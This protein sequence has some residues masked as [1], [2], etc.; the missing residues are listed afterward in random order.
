MTCSFVPPHLLRR[1]AESGT[2]AASP[3]TQTLRVDEQLRTQRATRAVAPPALDAAWVV[4]TAENGTTLPGRPVRSAGEPATGDAAVDE[5]ADGIAATLE[6]F[7][8]EFE[9]SSYDDAGAGVS[10]TV[11]Y[12]EDY[13]NAFWDGAHLVFGDGDGKVFDRFTKAVDVLA[14]E[15]AHAVT[16]HTAA[17]A[18]EGQSGA[19]N[20]SVS[21]VFACC[22]KQRLRGQQAGDADWLIGE[23]IFLP[24]VQA[25]ALRDMAAPG[26]AYDDPVLGKDP[27]V[28]H[29]DDYVETTDDNGGVHLNSGIP[30]R[31][32]HLAAV[33]IGGTTW[34]GAGSIWYAALTSGQVRADTDF[35]GFA[36][37]TVASAGDHAD[38]VREAWQAV[39]VEP[40]ADPATRPETAPE[41]APETQPETQPPPAEPA[42]PTGTVVVRRSGGFAGRSTSGV[43]DLDGEDP[44][45]GEVRDLVSGLELSR[46][47]PSPAM[48][49]M[50]TYTFEIGGAEPVALAEHEL[51]DR[52]HR[53]AG[54]VLSDAEDGPPTA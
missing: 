2:A 3:T 27:Q 51:D 41:T 42:V 1:I 52:L 47:K 54:I 21:D 13:D 28:G 36:A 7:A 49:D 20:E 43:V 5:A 29:L 17:L 44:R 48:P 45:A 32:F 24:G 16:E 37:A 6:M 19:L 40:G 33:A 9:R 26:T 15:F 50:F 4:H 14:H 46:G 10:L 18:Y 39:G 30:N 8:T 11:H 34:Q 25:R 22:L 31:A 12:G 23:A 35:A 53:L 38:A